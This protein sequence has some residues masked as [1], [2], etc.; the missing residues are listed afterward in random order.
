[1]KLFAIKLSGQRYLTNDLVGHT[2]RDHAA[3]FTDESS[4]RVVGEFNR[5]AIFP[6]IVEM[7]ECPLSEPTFYMPSDELDA[8]VAQ[9]VFGELRGDIE[10]PGTKCLDEEAILFASP[11]GGWLGYSGIRVLDIHEA[12]NAK[13]FFAAISFAGFIGDTGYY[14]CVTKLT[15]SEI[16]R[17]GKPLVVYF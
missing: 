11:Q 15:A 13:D 16:D 6:T 9:L 17:L 12:I 1:M 5:Y 8:S 7:V 10:I 3:L 14:P 2:D 4:L